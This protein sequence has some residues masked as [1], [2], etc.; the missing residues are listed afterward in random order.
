MTWSIL[1]VGPA[2]DTISARKRT[3]ADVALH[4][5]HDKRPANEWIFAASNEQSKCKTNGFKF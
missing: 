1:F 3:T 2:D 4:V 5:S